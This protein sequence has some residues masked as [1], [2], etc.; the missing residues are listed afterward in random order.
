MK[1]CGVCGFEIRGAREK[2]GALARRRQRHLKAHG[3]AA[4]FRRQTDHYGDWQWNTRKVDPARCSWQCPQEGCKVW[5]STEAVDGVS[6]A[7]FR[8]QRVAHIGGLQNPWVK[9]PAVPI[10]LFFAKNERPLD[11]DLC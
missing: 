3:V 2:G 6:K 8:E 9:N 7:W 10:K 1:T 11:A 5:A 4:D